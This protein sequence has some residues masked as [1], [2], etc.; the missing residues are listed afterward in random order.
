MPERNLFQF[1]K[2]AK[3]RFYHKDVMA[4]GGDIHTGATILISPTTLN[5][6]IQLTNKYSK[7][8]F[9]SILGDTVAIQ[10]EPETSFASERS[11]I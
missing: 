9:S 4:P 11:C 2:Y 8:L 10:K 5:F 6:G 1:T 7:I 3:S